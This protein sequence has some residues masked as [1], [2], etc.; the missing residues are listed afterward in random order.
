[1]INLIITLTIFQLDLWY[2]FKGTELADSTFATLK[3]TAPARRCWDF[4]ST[5]EVTERSSS[6]RRCQEA[7]LSDEQEPR[8]ALLHDWDHKAVLLFFLLQTSY[9][10]L[11]QESSRRRCSLIC[12]PYSLEDFFHQLSTV[13]LAKHHEQPPSAQFPWEGQK[14]SSSKPGEV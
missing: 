8:W 3:V 9:S 2:L 14:E 7:L 11:L 1:M 13:R 10:K 4:H 5:S 6:T 12:H